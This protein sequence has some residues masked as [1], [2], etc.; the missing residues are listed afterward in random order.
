MQTGSCSQCRYCKELIEDTQSF[1]TPITVRFVTPTMHNKFVVIDYD[2]LNG[3]SPTRRSVVATGSCN[4]SMSSATRYDEDWIVFEGDL[5]TKTIRA[6]KQEFE[7]LYAYSRQ[8]GNDPNDVSETAIVNGWLDTRLEWD[9]CF[10]S[11]NMEPVMTN[12]VWG[13]QYLRNGDD[14][15][16]ACNSKMIEA[17]NS[18][19]STI[20]IAHST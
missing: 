5:A 6:Y 4:W 3:P 13:F 14:V 7:F 2:S 11:Y 17:I 9:G 8:C 19:T 10:T 15:I 16:G 18:A 1:D 12:G 20:D